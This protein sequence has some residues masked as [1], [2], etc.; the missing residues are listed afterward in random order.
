MVRSAL[1]AS[2]WFAPLCLRVNGSRRDGRSLPRGSFVTA[3]RRCS[4]RRSTVCVLCPGGDGRVAPESVWWVA[5]EHHPRALP[6]RSRAS[7]QRER[8]IRFEMEQEREFGMRRTACR[9][10]ALSAGGGGGG[11][12]SWG[13]RR[14]RRYRLLF[15]QSSGAASPVH[16]PRVRGGFRRGLASPHPASSPKHRR[17]PPPSPKR[18]G[19]V[20]DGFAVARAGAAAS[21]SGQ[22]AAH[23]WRGDSASRF[24]ARLQVSSVAGTAAHPARNAALAGSSSGLTIDPRASRTEWHQWTAAL[25]IRSRSGLARSMLVTT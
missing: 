4:R 22:I 24:G 11:V 5:R 12:A 6:P 8:G 17:K 21:A 25:R 23:R 16:A 2:E 9:G 20:K 7:L 15:I 10:V 18:R 3:S 13:D 14:W 19:R 1:L